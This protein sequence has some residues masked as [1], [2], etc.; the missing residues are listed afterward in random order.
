MNSYGRRYII[1]HYSMMRNMKM[2][3]ARGA[4]S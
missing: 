3:V 4:A 1:K 2:F